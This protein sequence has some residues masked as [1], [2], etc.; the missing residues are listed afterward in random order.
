MYNEGFSLCGAF[1]HD[2]MEANDVPINLLRYAGHVSENSL[3]SFLIKIMYK[4]ILGYL[5]FN[6]T[7]RSQV[8]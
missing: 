4:R 1:S 2:V 3:L 8:L 6:K 5:Y 7:F